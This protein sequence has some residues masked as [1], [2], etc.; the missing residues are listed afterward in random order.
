MNTGVVAGERVNPY[1]TAAPVM[2]Q[3]SPQAGPQEG[4]ESTS[5]SGKPIVFRNGAWE[6]K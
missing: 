5:K 4:Q 6:Y 1:Q 2:M 3:P